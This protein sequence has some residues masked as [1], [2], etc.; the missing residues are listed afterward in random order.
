MSSSQLKVVRNTPD[1]VVVTFDEAVVRLAGLSVGEYEQ[2][3]KKE[4][5]QLNAR[6]TVLDKAVEAERDAQHLDAEAE[7]IVEILEPWEHTVNGEDLLTQMEKILE[8]YVI[9]PSGATPAVALWMLASYCMDSWTIFPKLLVNSPDSQCGKSTLLDILE[10]FSHRALVASNIT[11]SA[12]F[13]CID[14]YGPTLILDEADT[15]MKGNSE[16]NGIINA[17]H[18]K[19]GANVIKTETVDKKHVPVKRDVWCPQVI[20]GIGEQRRTLHNRSIVIAMQR[21]LTSETVSKLPR[22]A[23]E[24]GVSFRRKC[25]RW[26]EDNAKALRGKPIVPVNIGDDRAQDNWEPLYMVANIVGGQWIKKAEDSYNILTAA[27]TEAMPTSLGEMVLEDIRDV[28]SRLSVD[29]IF[30]DDLVTELLKLK[31]RPWDDIGNGK[32]LTQAGLA[33]LLKLYKCSHGSIRIGKKSRKGYYLKNF[34]KAF[35][36]YL[37]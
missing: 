37:K 24:Q 3:R 13:R 2:C 35:E 17:G 1:P 30:S 36:R 26:V 27:A 32:I 28:F 18:K 29:K 8:S 15:Y 10:C 20:A 12:L 16:M 22:N 7:S 19:R 31:D 34:G 14:L 6:N 25:A 9:L 21:K 23:Y 33:K 5:K 11:A 4:A